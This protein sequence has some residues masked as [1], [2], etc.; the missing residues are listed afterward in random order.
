M[1]TQNIPVTNMADGSVSTAVSEQKEMVHAIDK[2]G[3]YV[4][5]VDKTVAFQQVPMPPN[6]KC[7][8]DFT[9]A[10]W[11]AYETNDDKRRAIEQQIVALEG[12]QHRAV[13]DSIILGDKTR[14]VALDT[15]IATL[16]VHYTA[17]PL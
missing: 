5:L 17:V 4:G 15:Q 6:A 10:L 14:L 8:W 7:T 2:T 9:R 11:N 16:R 13:R 1:T 12:R 3:A